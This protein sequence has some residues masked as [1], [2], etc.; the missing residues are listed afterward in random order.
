MFFPPFIR[1]LAGGLLLSAAGGVGL[2]WFLINHTE[3]G[4]GVNSVLRKRIAFTRVDPLAQFGFP[5]LGPPVRWYS[6]HAVGWNPELRVPSWVAEHVTKDSLHGPGQSSK[7]QFRMDPAVPQVWS[8]SDRD[9]KGSDWIRGHLVPVED[10]KGS[11]QAMDETF[12]YSNIVPQYKTNAEGIWR[13]LEDYCRE[14]TE[15]FQDVWVVSG[16]LFRPTEGTQRSIKYQIIGDAGVAVP[17]HLYKVVVARGS[18]K[19]HPTLAAFVIPNSPIE[20]DWSL[21]SFQTELIEVERTAG[22]TFFPRLA[23][24]GVHAPQ[25][26]CAV[27]VCETRAFLD[28]WAMERRKMRAQG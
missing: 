19:Q 22:L 4:C 17:T 8:A 25:D 23:R 3:F 20:A 15:R 16:P 2:R 21:H 1:G 9:Y 12:L 24:V 18:S 14:L 7:A 11:Q 27:D 6:T 13:S 26:L 28:K 5:D 10:N